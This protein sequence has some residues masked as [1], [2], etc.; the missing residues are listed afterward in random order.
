MFISNFEETVI[1]LDKKYSF[2]FLLIYTMKI[3]KVLRQNFGDEKNEILVS[4]HP[5]DFPRNFPERR[6]LH[7]RSF[8]NQ[9]KEKKTRKKQIN[10]TSRDQKRIKFANLSKSD[11]KRYVT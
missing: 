6:S 7:V 9:N 2:F 8:V 1:F 11:I 4:Y 10:N 5:R 3:G